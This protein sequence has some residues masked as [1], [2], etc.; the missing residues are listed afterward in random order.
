MKDELFK[1]TEQLEENKVGWIVLGEFESSK[2]NNLALESIPDAWC[3]IEFKINIINLGDK[4]LVVGSPDIPFDYEDIMD[5]VKKT[6][7]DNEISINTEE[8]YK[9]IEKI[10]VGDYITT[11]KD[12]GIKIGSPA[13]WTWRSDSIFYTDDNTLS[14][15][16]FGS[17]ECNGIF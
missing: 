7:E 2:Q 10:S 17:Q 15:G 13:D 16:I 5:C 3:G 12:T 9:L 4:R 11:T 8:L 14:N 1:I 6:Y